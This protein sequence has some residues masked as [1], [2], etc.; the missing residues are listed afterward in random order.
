MLET[1][2][3]PPTCT[4]IE[5]LVYVSPLQWGSEMRIR[6]DFGWWKRGWFTNGLAF[7]WDLKSGSLTI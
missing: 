7:E 4:G 6:P 3:E 1:T 2:G 5:K